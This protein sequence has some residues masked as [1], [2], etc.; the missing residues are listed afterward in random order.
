M[1]APFLIWAVRPLLLRLIHLNN[2]QVI[3]RRTRLPL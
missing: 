1:H 2:L 3:G